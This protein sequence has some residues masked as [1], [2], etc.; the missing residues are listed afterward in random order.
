M[1]YFEKL[2]VAGVPEEQAKVQALVFRDFNTLQEENA[3]LELATKAD[4]REA[5]LRLQ[6]EIQQVKYD[7]LKWQIA[8]W[9]VLA[10]SM[11]RWHLNYCGRATKFI[12]KIL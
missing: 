8:G 11:V 9:V 6:K 1:S 12:E 2:T 4:L 10:A 7:L 3:K 5:E